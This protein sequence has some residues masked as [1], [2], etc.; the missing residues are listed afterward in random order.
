MT[1]NRLQFQAG[2]SMSDFLDCYG[3]KENVREGA[4]SKVQLLLASAPEMGALLNAMQDT[5]V[6][7]LYGR[8]ILVI[9]P[10]RS[11]RLCA[12]S[13]RTWQTQDLSRVSRCAGQSRRSGSCPP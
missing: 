7:R 6:Q 5:S 1:M 13:A 8:D 4:H 2:L 12:A 9:E 3:S 10:Y 11:P